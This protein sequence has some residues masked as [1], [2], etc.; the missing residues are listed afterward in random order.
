MSPHGGSNGPRMATVAASLRGEREN[1]GLYPLESST[2]GP[3]IGRGLPSRF[4]AL[5]NNSEENLGDL[6][7]HG[8][9][10]KPVTLA[11]LC[12]PD[13]QV[14]ADDYPLRASVFLSVKRTQ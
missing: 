12:I 14:V 1:L 4:H 5:P 13:T 11:W 10:P 9:R 8:F 3:P 2:R 6:Q 7:E